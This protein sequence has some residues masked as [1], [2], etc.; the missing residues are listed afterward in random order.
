MNW[1]DPSWVKNVV[2][3]EGGSCACDKETL[4]K[5]RKFILENAQSWIF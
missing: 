3:S 5:L 2:F 4:E 1:D